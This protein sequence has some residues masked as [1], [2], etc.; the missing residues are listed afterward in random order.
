MMFGILLIGFILVCTG[1]IVKLFLSD[2]LRWALIITLILGLG[3][4]VYFASNGRLH[5]WDERYH[6]LVAKN[7]IEE[8]FKPMLY[9]HP[10]LP[11]DYKSWDLNHIWLH[12]QPMTLW[13]MALSIKIFGNNIWAVRLVSLLMSMILIYIVYLMG[14]KLFNQKI[15]LIAAFLFAINGFVLEI[16]S[17]RAST[18][19]VDLTFLFYTSIAIFLAILGAEKKS[20]IYASLVGFFIGFAILTKWLPALIVLPIW[21]LSCLHYKRK[22][23]FI[24][25]SSIVILLLANVIALPWQLYIFDKFPTE[26]SYESEYNTRHV[27]EP[28][29]TEK[30]F[31]WYNLKHL[32][33]KFG[34]LIYLP[35]A[36]FTFF[37]FRKRFSSL[38]NKYF[39]LWIWIFI[40]LIIFTFVKTK[41][42]GYILFCAPALFI[43]ISYVWYVFA[44]KFRRNTYYN[45]LAF[46]VLVVLPVRYTIE[47]AK[48]F[49]LRFLEH[50]EETYSK[51]QIIFNDRF[52]VETMFFTDCYASYPILPTA[53]IID[54]LT[55]SGFEVVVK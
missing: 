29:G 41:M 19:H 32:R 33:I 45:V 21:I 6:A 20:W 18:D 4:R 1:A 44:Y 10:V 9:K 15:G 42:P 2:K 31:L 39:L 24:F 27:F 48:P 51:N 49:E 54:S 14:N 16:G 25:Q 23:P 38:R 26:A 35:L 13:M 22:W 37:V 7:M 3:L 12:K 17:G 34:E 43:V 50:Y 40:P 46:I 55:K 28:L 8:P 11:Y 5:D 53:T 30:S 47:R 52:Y 36:I